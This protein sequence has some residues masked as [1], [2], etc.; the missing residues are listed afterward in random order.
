MGNGK[1]R[2]HS[3]NDHRRRGSLKTEKPPRP[4]RT[5]EG[6]TADRRQQTADDILYHR[7]PQNERGFIMSAKTAKIRELKELKA[8]AEQVAAEITAIEDEIKA[9]MLAR[10]VEE[11]A[12]DVYKVRWTMVKSSRLDSASLKKAMPE[13]YSQFTKQTTSRRFSVA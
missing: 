8:L 4:E 12:V 9:E 6:A 7:R 3:P 13:L 1:Q 10:G 2:G 11:L 5:G